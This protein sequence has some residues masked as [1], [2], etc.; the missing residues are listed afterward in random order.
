MEVSK[1]SQILEV[2]CANLS[3][4]QKPL[5]QSQFM[6]QL[7]FGVP[8]VSTTTCITG[9]HFSGMSWFNFNIHLALNVRL[10]GIGEVQYQ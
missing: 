9:D 6:S 3:N 7:L 8:G 10:T 4:N 2:H 1:H 5:R